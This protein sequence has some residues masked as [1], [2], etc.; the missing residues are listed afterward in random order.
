MGNMHGGGLHVMVHIGFEMKVPYGKKAR[1]SV[2][3]T[4]KLEYHSLTSSIKACLIACGSVS[5]E[6]DKVFP[7]FSAL[8]R[9]PI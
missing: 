8:L 3:G 2:E 5:S 7:F 6:A 4:R 1:T 9:K